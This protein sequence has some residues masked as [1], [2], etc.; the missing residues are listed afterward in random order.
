M[1]PEL[2]RVDAELA[3]EVVIGLLDRERC[4]RHAEAAKGAAGWR[5]GEDCPVAG[6]HVGDAVGA[7]AWIGTRPATV[8]PQEA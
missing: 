1:Q 3:G 4:L 2:E 7:G 8:G 5:V 6:A